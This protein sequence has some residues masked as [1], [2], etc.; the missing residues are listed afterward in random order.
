MIF[1]TIVQLIM[2]LEHVQIFNFMGLPQA[3]GLAC[4]SRLTGLIENMYVG[5]STRA[6]DD[7][8]LEPHFACVP[9]LLES[10]SFQ[11]AFDFLIKDMDSQ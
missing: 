4:I 11:K 7:D 2:N 3:F 6:A 10:L 9:F 1:E 8:H 5:H